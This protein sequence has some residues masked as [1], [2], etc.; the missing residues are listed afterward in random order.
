VRRPDFGAKP[1]RTLDLRKEFYAAAAVFGLVNALLLVVN[2]I[3]IRWLW[4]GFVPKPGFDLTQFVHEGTYVLIFSILLAMG[5]V[6]W[7]FRRNLNFYAA[8]LPLLRWGATVWVLQNAVLAASVGLR[9][10]YYILH[11]GLAYKRIGVCF[12]LLLTLF[13]LGTVLLKIWQRRSAYGLVRLN[14]LAVYAV[15]LMLAAGNWEVWMARYNLQSRFRTIDIG[16]LLDMPGRV[17]PTLLARR[18]LLNHTPQL[19]GTNEYGTY[20]T[21]KAED[22][23]RRLDLAL[24]NWHAERA[25]Y[26]HWQSRTWSDWQTAKELNVRE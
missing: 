15:L 9:N 17:L 21:L 4:F 18:E 16:F 7:F 22:A 6:L 23:Q 8:G 13:G 19:T 5:I 3:D 1:F 14:A 26:P 20:T 2:A 11:A 10:Y 25:A 24:A 12:F